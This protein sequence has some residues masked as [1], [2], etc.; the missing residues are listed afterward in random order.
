MKRLRGD[1]RGKQRENKR[2]GRERR[3]NK[4]G[5]GEEEEEDN[6]QME[7]QVFDLCR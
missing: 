7:D 4:A 5:G 6:L 2:R 1:W 3:E